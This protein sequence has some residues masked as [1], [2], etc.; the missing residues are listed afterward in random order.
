MPDGLLS[1][2]TEKLKTAHVGET[3]HAVDDDRT[4]GARPRP[5]PHPRAQRLGVLLLRQGKEA[6]R[7]F[8]LRTDRMTMGR[9]RASDIVL[10]DPTVSRVHAMVTR[11][12]AGIY[13]IVDQDSANGILV[14]NQPISEHVLEDGDEIQI[15]MLVLAFRQ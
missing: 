1:R 7:A 4:R 13:R 14:N 5:H 10:E 15:G 3:T 8:E 9:S 11:D 2:Y 6:A 12:A